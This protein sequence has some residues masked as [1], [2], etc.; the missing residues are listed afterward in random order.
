MQGAVNQYT[1]VNASQRKSF[2]DTNL[3]LQVMAE[4]T[5]IQF[6]FYHLTETFVFFVELGC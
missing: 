4:F 3:A 5:A 6:T 1:A 2:N